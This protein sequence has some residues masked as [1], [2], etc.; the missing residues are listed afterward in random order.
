M[1]EQLRERL[2][3]TETS[4]G[5]KDLTIHLETG[6]I[7]VKHIEVKFDGMVEEKLGVERSEIRVLKFKT[8]WEIKWAFEQ[9]PFLVKKSDQ[10]VI[11]TRRPGY[12]KGKDYLLIVPADA[13]H[14]T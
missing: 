7:K 4:Q 2:E 10:V 12:K 5:Q 3:K 1:K 11:A 6:D 9:N 14:I 13:P 8:P